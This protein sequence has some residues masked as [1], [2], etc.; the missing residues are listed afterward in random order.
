MA[1]F[2]API[3]PSATAQRTA[4]RPVSD[5]S[6]RSKSITLEAGDTLVTVLVDAG[7]PYAEALAASTGLKPVVDLRNL[8]PGQQITLRVRQAEGENE[9]THLQRLALVPETD[10][11]VL[12]IHRKDE[13]FDAKAEEVDHVRRLV[14][15]KGEIKASLYEAARGQNVPMTVLLQA[16]RTLGHAV[17]LQRD[18]RSGDEF[19]FGY[20]LFDDGDNGDLHPGDLQYASLRMEDRTFRV[21]RYTT[22]D[23]YTG[24]FN[25]DGRSIETSLMKTPVDGGRL[26]SLFGKRDHPILGYTRMHKGLDFAAPRGAPVLAAGDGIVERRRRYGSFGNYVRIRHDSTYATAYAHLSRYSKGLRKGERV[27]QGEVIGYV[28]STGMATGPNLHYEVL[29][30]GDQVNPIKLELPPRR[31]LTGEPLAR[32]R[33]VVAEMTEKLDAEPAD[34]AQ[35]DSP[36]A[37]PL[38]PNSA[39]DA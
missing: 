16:Y 34:P 26:S 13:E 9:A 11:K 33:R 5:T 2:H 4:A 22:G 15:A 37:V 39:D 38:P 32:F 21:Y 29:A 8:K 14:F 6:L 36:I 1:S 17:D 24:F 10:R 27:R 23:G 28:G 18:L 31:V 35:T 30:D 12:A 3:I 19:A 7:V 25:V 20:E